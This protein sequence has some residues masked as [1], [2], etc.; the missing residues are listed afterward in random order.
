MDIN[1]LINKL[2]EDDLEFNLFFTRK[3]SN[4]KYISFSPN[5]CPQICSDLLNLIIDHIRQFKDKSIVG[6]NPTGCKDETI[7]KCNISY[8]NDYD[9]VLE[10]FANSD[11]VETEIDPDTY[12]FYTFSITK[13]DDI[14]PEIKIFRRVTKFK[15]LNS[16]GIIARFNGNTLNKIESKLIGIDGEV[17]LIVAG[18]DMLILSHYSLERIFNLDKQF[19][20]TTSDFLNQEGLS[21]G[22]VNFEIFYEDCLNDGRYRKVLTKMNNENINI[23]ETYKNHKNI[24]KTIDMF[25]LDIN[26]NE[27]HSFSII[28]KDKSQIMDILRI[29]R[30]SYYKSIIN[31]Q[32]GIDDK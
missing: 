1:T 8:I 16:K 9:K 14:F 17:D 25:N 15:K 13:N 5:I 3:L 18:N 30:D 20:N 31:E 26:Y 2:Q 28:Y 32:M 10:S 23:L 24:K 12:S 29:L 19:R 4:G 27:Q 6:Y 22:I 11:C 7:E 21:S